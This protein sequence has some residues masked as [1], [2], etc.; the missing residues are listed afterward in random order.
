MVRDYTQET[1]LNLKQKVD[2]IEEEMEDVV[3]NPGSWQTEFPEV[4][5]GEIPYD[6]W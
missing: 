2:E 6:I 5:F 3:I 1:L 4:D